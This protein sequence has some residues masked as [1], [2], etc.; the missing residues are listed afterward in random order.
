MDEYVLNFIGI[1]EIYRDKLSR[2]L[3]EKNFCILYLNLSYF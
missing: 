2:L 3:Y 1:P